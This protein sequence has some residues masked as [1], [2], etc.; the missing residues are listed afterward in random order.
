MKKYH[1]QILSLLAS[2]KIDHLFVDVSA[3]ADE[4]AL[5]MISASDKLL[6]VLVNEPTS[7]MAVSYTHLTL[8]TKA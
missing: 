2:Q 1:Q 4:M 5:N 3:G 8:P 6:I 7:F